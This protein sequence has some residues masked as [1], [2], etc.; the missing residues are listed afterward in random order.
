[1]NEAIDNAVEN[2]LLPELQAM[3][4]MDQA[5]DIKRG[6]GGKISTDRIYL[7]PVIWEVW[8]DR[9]ITY[10]LNKFQAEGREHRLLDPIHAI[11]FALQATEGLEFLRWWNEGDWKGCAQDW[12]EWLT[13]KQ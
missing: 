13:F 8:L 1:V 12:P 3:S 5:S 9:D 10:I 2:G 11:Q 4:W 7:V 6:S